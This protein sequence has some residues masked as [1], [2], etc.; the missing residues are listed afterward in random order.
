MDFSLSS[1]GTNEERRRRIKTALLSPAL[2]LHPMEERE[3]NVKEML[4]WTKT[5]R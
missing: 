2:L 5:T 1:R 3:K 4:Y